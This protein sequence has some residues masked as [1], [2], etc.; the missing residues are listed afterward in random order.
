[1]AVLPAPV[2]PGALESPAQPHPGRRTR[3][4]RP[5]VL[6]L[7]TVLAVSVLSVALKLQVP[8]Y[9]NTS[10]Y[11][12][13]LFARNAIL[14]EGAHWLGPFSLLN[15][16]KGPGYP[17]FIAVAHTVGV[18]LAAAEQVVFLVAVAAL[19][20]CVLAVTG[21]YA[22]ATACFVVL[23]LDPVNYSSA[24]TDVLR[25][26]LYASQ[27]LFFVAS[28]ALVVLAVVR[29]ARL[30]WIVAAGLLCGGAGGFAWLTRE[31][32]PALLPQVLVLAALAWLFARTRK[33]DRTVRGRQR[34]RGLARPLIALGVA[35]AAFAGPVVVVSA[36]N[37]Q[38]YGVRVTNDLGEGT[39]LRAYADWTRVVV[40]EEQPQV[41]INA[42]K[43]RL[44]YA[45]SPAASALR[46]ELE[47]PDNQ[48]R[49]INCPT[50]TCDYGG[51]WMIWAIREAAAEAGYF[52]DARTAQQY[53]A[54]LSREI[55]E[56]C[57]SGELTCRPRL[58]ASLQPIQRVELDALGTS[59]ERL[60]SD[61]VWSRT[62]MDLH[63]LNT[64]IPQG[65]RDEYTAIIHGLPESNRAAQQAFD[66]FDERRG[67]FEGLISV[68]R[69]AVPVLLVV[70]VVGI[71]L[72]LVTR[73]RTAATRRP[74]SWLLPVL[75]TALFAGLAVRL[76][77]LSIID[78]AE[79]DAAQGRYQLPNHVFLV[80][81]ALVVIASVTSGLL[82]AR[83]GP[84]ER[85]AGSLPGSAPGG[86]QADGEPHDGQL[87]AA[88]DQHHAEDR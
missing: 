62:L 8:T 43:R 37:A 76:V 64:P 47:R 36:V 83:R 58:P 32:G 70:S 10:A 5:A 53:F 13:L 69:T 15:L 85:A 7:L 63:P 14:L 78:S 3:I 11:D 16:S 50:G 40:D 2:P 82:D 68:Y 77:L 55:D 6:S 84:T 71:V 73:R 72:T 29:R 19:C 22:V 25:D 59:L 75:A 21:R 27:S 26:N 80:A 60:T 61:L 1:M 46:G 20:A 65:M 56:A 74:T 44:V 57:T 88:D 87:R 33:R 41:P 35:A 42:E 9:L 52:R 23:A 24:S 49:F 18:P 66:R 12:G 54:R 48:W 81:L 45:V 79:Y 17:G 28:A 67:L 31:E 39:F 51:G 34:L 30:R 86:D 4:R 38:Q